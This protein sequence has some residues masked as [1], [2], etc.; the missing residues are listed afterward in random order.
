MREISNGAIPDIAAP[1]RLRLLTTLIFY[2][3][4]SRYVSKVPFSV[5]PAT[6]SSPP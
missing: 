3:I 6:A 4:T 1:I 5:T 2:S